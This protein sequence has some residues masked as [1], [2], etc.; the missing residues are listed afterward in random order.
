MNF[1][2]RYTLVMIVTTA[3]VGCSSENSTTTSNASPRVPDQ[4]TV[5]GTAYLL[6]TEPEGAGDVTK[7]R[8]E[9]GTD[10]ELLVIGRIGGSSNPWIDGRAAFTIV[11]LSVKSCNDTLD[12]KCP[13]PWDYCCETSKLPTS[14]ALVKFVDETDQVIRADARSLFD[15]QELSTVVIKGTAKRDEAGNLTVLA[16]GLFV[17][18]K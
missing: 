5:D 14:T 3:L 2:E 1:F 7:V 12:D 10:D 4:A 9:V 16:N 6:D 11:D 17:K 18:Q 15:L 13:T 8:E